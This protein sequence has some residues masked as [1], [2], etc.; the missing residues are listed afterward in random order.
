MVL[1]GYV[2]YL[3]LVKV[4]GWAG[5]WV[6]SV[7]L[8][9]FDPPSHPEVIANPVGMHHSSQRVLATVREGFEKSRPP[10][11]RQLMELMILSAMF[12]DKERFVAIMN[13][14]GGNFLQSLPHSSSPE[15]VADVSF[16]L[17][18]N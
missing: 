6:G 12:L 3:P 14:C 17:S 11:E 15:G 4:H 9:M 10:S 5:Q 7:K 18:S 2:S 1:R 13:Y 8:A 16:Y